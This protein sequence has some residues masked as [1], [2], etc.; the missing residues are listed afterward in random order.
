MTNED[1]YSN[2]RFVRIFKASA[3]RADVFYK[4]K[5]PYV[6]VCVCVRIDREMLCLPYAGFFIEDLDCWISQFS[7]WNGPYIVR[8]GDST[9]RL[10]ITFDTWI[11][12]SI[13]HFPQKWMHNNLFLH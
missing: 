3:L 9:G 1:I 13:Y 6:C 2:R 7:F 5:C 10:W 4:S 11:K 8:F 12:C